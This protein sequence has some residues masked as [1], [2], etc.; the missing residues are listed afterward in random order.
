MPHGPEKENGESPRDAQGIPEKFPPER[1]NGDVTS[2]ES[3]KQMNGGE[4]TNAIQKQRQFQLTILMNN[5]L[6]KHQHKGK[7]DGGEQHLKRY[8][9]QHQRAAEWSKC[10]TCSKPLVDQKRKPS[11]GGR[12]VAS[13][14][15]VAMHG[16]SLVA[17]QAKRKT[18][19]SCF[20]HPHGHE[21]PHA[22]V[23]G[24]GRAC[25][26]TG[27]PYRSTAPYPSRY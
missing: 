9:E 23:P 11:V 25:R 8:G 27:M 22:K 14:C 16:A 26:K 13:A 19:T 1:S 10:M 20:D 2:G 3:G 4:Q 7:R 24:S 5:T 18:P 6:R 21:S 17:G 12:S 15:F